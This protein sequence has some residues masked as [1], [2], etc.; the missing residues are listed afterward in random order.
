L[1]KSF[2]IDYNVTN[3]REARAEEA[4]ISLK[5]AGHDLKK[6]FLLDIGCGGGSTTKWISN[7][8]G[9]Y[10]IGLEV[11][12]NFRRGNENRNPL[13]EY[14]YASGI[15]LPFKEK[16][17]HSV[18]LNDVLEHVSYRD[19]EEL[20]NEI[21]KVLDDDGMLYVSVASKYEIREPHSNMLFMSWFPRFVFSPIVR[22]IF[23]DDVYPYTAR[24]FKTL[25]ENTKFASKN[26]TWL[27]V[28]KK[29]QNINYIGNTIIRPLARMLNKLGLTKNAG[30]LKFL[31]P[32]G[33]LLF[34]CRKR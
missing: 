30:F 11:Q 9:I 5:M 7:N 25:A 34:V 4:V 2:F 24:R 28:S 21:R 1:S 20:F 19:A 14:A 31:E 32:F 6:G 26:F 10:S 3:N 8:L 18:V 16:S 17:F 23:H 22:K 29:M 15:K 27:Y 13:L 12:K 33:V